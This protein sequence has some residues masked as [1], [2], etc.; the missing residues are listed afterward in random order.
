MTF[1]RS[2]DSGFCS[3]QCLDTAGE[4]AGRASDLQL[5]K[6]LL[7]STLNLRFCVHKNRIVNQT[8]YYAQYTTVLAC[9]SGGPQNLEDKFGRIVSNDLE[10]GNLLP[11]E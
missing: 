1:L 4:A 8:I 3:C 10:V 11:I 2:L 6:I 9:V 5:I 7:I